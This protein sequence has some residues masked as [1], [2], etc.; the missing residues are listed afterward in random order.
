[1]KAFLLFLFI[2]QSLSSQVILQNSK[3]QNA[4]LGLTSSSGGGGIPTAN[5]IQNSDASTVSGS[6]GDAISTLTATIGKDLTTS[7]TG[8]PTL[9]TGGSGKNGLNTLRFDGVAN[10]MQSINFV[11]GVTQPFTVFIVF[12]IN[13]TTP[14]VNQFVFD[15]NDSTP[16]ALLRADD[17]GNYEVFGGTQFSDTLVAVNTSWHIISITFNGASSKFSIDGGVES[18]LPDDIGS[19]GLSGLTLGAAFNTTS[20]PTT[21]DFGQILIY[22]VPPT[23]STVMTPLNAKWGVY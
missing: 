22:S 21:M 2:C 8:R 1:M 20:G 7:G 12:K 6:T 3:L 10:Y 11:S 9:E 17:G 5:L 23:I 18:T 4:Q 16:R 14:G 19:N 13:N 15:N